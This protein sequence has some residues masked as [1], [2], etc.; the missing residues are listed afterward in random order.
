MGRNAQSCFHKKATTKA[1]KRVA[2]GIEAETAE[3]L[4]RVRLRRDGGSVY[5]SPAPKADA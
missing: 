1:I 3:T 4:V 2:S 5:E